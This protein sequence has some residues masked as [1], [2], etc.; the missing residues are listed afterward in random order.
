MKG[1]VLAGGFGSRL[2]PMTTVVSKQLLPVYNKPMVFYPI[3]ILM[4]SKI[5]DILI[6]S[7]EQNIDGFRK[8]LGIGTN[9]GVNF[10]YLTQDEPKGIAEAL[11]IGSEFIGQDD[12]VLILGDNV[13]YGADIDSVLSIAKNNLNS[14]YSTIFANN[15]KDPERFGVVEIDDLN[16]PIS[17]VEK[18]LKPKSNFAVTGLYFYKN[19]VVKMFN[20]LVPS[21]R[22]EYEISDINQILLNN[23]KLKVI[24]LERGFAWFDTG[25]P[26]ALIEASSFIRIIEN[27][28]SI[29]IACLEEISFHNDWINEDDL[30][31]I[32]SNNLNSDYNKYL[33]NLLTK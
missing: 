9:L 2:Y 18:P 17:I 6:I 4:Q 25:T 16:N 32:T 31:L 3:A 5:K 1:I 13:F 19:D 15:V 26:D 7:D 23:K 24:K 30:F 27:N 8:L 20:T 22:N 11:K 33:R 10:S 21:S 29:M 14:G 28:Q 12:F